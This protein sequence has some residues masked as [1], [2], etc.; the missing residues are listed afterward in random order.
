MPHVYVG[1]DAAPPAAAAPPREQPSR[2]ARTGIEW[3]TLIGGSLF[4]YI[5]AIFI[6]I[7]L[8]LL[9]ILAFG[10]GWITPAILVIFGICVG[11]GL[12][13]GGAYFHRPDLRPCA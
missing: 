9:I 5:G 3:E 8:A 12:I 4:S 1:A 13:A 10:E 11:A 2:R 7:G 6:L